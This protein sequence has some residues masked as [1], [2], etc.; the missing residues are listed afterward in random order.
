MVHKLF[1]KI[2]KAFNRIIKTLILVICT[3]L[4]TGG[5]VVDESAVQ[6]VE[7][8]L[9]SSMDARNWIKY[10]PENIVE[11]FYSNGGEVIYVDKIEDSTYSA[12]G[13]VREF[14][15]RTKSKVNGIYS[16][17]ELTITVE[18][19]SKDTVIHEFGHYWWYKKLSEEQRES[20]KDIWE[21][22][23]VSLYA[24]VNLDEG[25]AEAFKKYFNPLLNGIEYKLY[26]LSFEFIKQTTIEGD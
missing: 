22:E 2:F 4:I 19:Y 21:K 9:L 18:K 5:I 7:E 13:S 23:K 14:L 16:S 15:E 11:D 10:V 12:K 1:R 20:Y 8:K 17:R 3:L 6:Y 25:Y 26:P 24:D